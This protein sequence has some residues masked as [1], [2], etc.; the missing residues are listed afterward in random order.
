MLTSAEILSFLSHHMLSKEW[1]EFTYSFS[2]LND[3]TVEDWGG[4]FHVGIKVN[5]R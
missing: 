1:V 4:V 2:N 5:P 3:A